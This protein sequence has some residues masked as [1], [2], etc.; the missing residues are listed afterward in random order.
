MSLRP[1]KDPR[2][3]IFGWDAAD[4]AVIEEGWRRGMLPTLKS[5]ADRGQFG[6][7]LSTIPPVTPSAWTSFLTGV[8]S[9]E[10]GVFNFRTVRHSD[11]RIIPTNGGSRRVPTLIKG[12][13]A[14]GVSTCLVTVPWTYPAEPLEHGVV[15]PGWDDP[16]EGFDTTWPTEAGELLAAHVARVPRRVAFHGEAGPHLRRLAED[17]AL[18]ARVSDLL[19]DAFDPR[20]FMVVYVE[21]DRAGHLLWTDGV[22]PSTLVDAYEQV[23]A[24]M[25]RFMERWVRDDDV[26]L[27]ASDHGTR[28]VHSVVQIGP[29]LEAGGW[30]TVADDDDAPRFAKTLKRLVWSRIPPRLRNRIWRNLPSGRREEGQ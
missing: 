23:D 15:V 18:R 28:P 29:L 5:I 14:A 20:V 22:V 19:M 3:F 30:L 9:G 4:W 17:V 24:A 7:L 10:H 8:D 26:V 6:T 25:G 13:D 1:A 2:L 21:P 16:G 12:L 27:V 11:H